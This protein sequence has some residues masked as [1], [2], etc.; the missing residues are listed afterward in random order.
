M[1]KHI[2]KRDREIN[3][4]VTR[5]GLGKPD[6]LIKVLNERKIDYL[7]RRT[8]E[9][10]TIIFS[11]TK[12]IFP[13]NTYFR[14][15]KLFLFKMVKNDVVKWV[16]DRKSIKPPPKHDP[17]YYNIDYDDSYGSIVAVDLNHAYWRIAFSYG[18][19][20]ENTYLKGLD[21]KCKAI[22]LAA[23]SVLGKKREFIRYMGGEIV[24]TKTL[25]EENK[26]LLGVYTY[27]RLFCYQM[28]YDMSKMLGDD[29][30]CW[31]TD[32]IYFRKTKKNIKMITKYLGERNFSFKMTDGIN[33]IVLEEGENYKDINFS[34]F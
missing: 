10:T 23:L 27:I 6:N 22:R 28:M 24:E 33:I 4:L 34:D 12:F 7:M 20:S 29:F 9:S 13:H 25:R 15:G 30:D 11:D 32:C 19:I 2:E 16:G 26:A 8:T 5:M 18:I 3:P 21:P 17:S 14:A 1:G 31:R